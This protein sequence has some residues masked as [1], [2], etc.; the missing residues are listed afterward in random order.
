[1]RLEIAGG[2]LKLQDELEQRIELMGF[3]VA[4]A[5]FA[6]AA[7]PKKIRTIL[8]RQRSSSVARRRDAVRHEHR[9]PPP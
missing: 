1:M 8:F 5:C 7:V 9:A 3:A 4:F 2:H 6:V